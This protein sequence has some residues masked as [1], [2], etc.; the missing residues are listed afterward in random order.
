MQLPMNPFGLSLKEL[1]DI[2]TKDRMTLATIIN[3]ML[4]FLSR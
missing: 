3:A 2:I 1:W 4:C